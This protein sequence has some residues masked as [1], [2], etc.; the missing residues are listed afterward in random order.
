MTDSQAFQQAAE[1]AMR[2]A[3][4]QGLRE[5]IQAEAL[6][7]LHQCDEM[8]IPQDLESIVDCLMSRLVGPQS[9][10]AWA[11]AYAAGIRMAPGLLAAAE[12]G[13]G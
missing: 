4:R 2:E 12:G 1:R 8:T 6:R 10:I 3:L 13:A 7:P 5:A 11:L 9:D